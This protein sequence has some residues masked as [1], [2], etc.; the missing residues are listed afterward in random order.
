MG[1]ESSQPTDIID[2]EQAIR[3]QKLQE[4]QDISSNY[5]DHLELLIDSRKNM[6]DPRDVIMVLKSNLKTAR[7]QINK[8]TEPNHQQQHLISTDINTNRLQLTPTDS[9]STNASSLLSKSNQSLMLSLNNRFPYGLLLYIFCSN[10]LHFAITQKIGRMLIL[11]KYILINANW[12][13][14]TAYQ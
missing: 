13:K 6:E 3:H 7:E 10:C 9:N 5:L 12:V 2:H 8:L 14:S 11:S 4:L 1:N